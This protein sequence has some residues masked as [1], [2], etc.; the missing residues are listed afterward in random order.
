[1]A[2]GV[3]IDL[4][5][6]VGG[7]HRPDVAALDHDVAIVGEL[8]LA[9]AH[10]LA[11]GLVS[12]DDR[13]HPVDVGLAD[14]GGDVGAPDPDAALLVEHDRV[15]VGGL[16]ESVAFGAGESTLARGPA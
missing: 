15:L 2:L 5:L 10:D 9:R 16:A 14:G 8:A 1:V 4:D 13:N 7:H 11:Y 6:G 12:G 3:E